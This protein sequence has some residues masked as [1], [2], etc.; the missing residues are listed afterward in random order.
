MRMLL[1]E[2]ADV[3]YPNKYMMKASDGKGGNRTIMRVAPLTDIDV[4]ETVGTTIL[5]K[6][7]GASAIISSATSF[8]E[9]GA[10]IVEF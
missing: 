1:D 4:K 5:G 3:I 8:S 7:S 2:T 9:G 10:A 6:T